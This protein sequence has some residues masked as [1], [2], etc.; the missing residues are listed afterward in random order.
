MN[1]L[2]AAEI[3]I[4]QNRGAVSSPL[5]LWMVNLAGLTSWM[6]VLI[7]QHGWV[8]YPPGVLWSLSVEEMFY[9]LFPAELVSSTTSACHRFKKVEGP[10]TTS[11]QFSRSR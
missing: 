1:L 3:P 6:K 5:S 7:A 8:N 10:S 11:A 9:L 4:F 2:A